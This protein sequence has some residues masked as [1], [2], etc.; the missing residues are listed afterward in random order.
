[1]K[2]MSGGTLGEIILFGFFNKKRSDN[3]YFEKVFET[4]KTAYPEIHQIFR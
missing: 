3:I 1:M 4:L 2:E